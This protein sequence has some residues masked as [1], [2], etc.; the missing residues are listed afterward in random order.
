MR[1]RS[2]IVFYTELAYF[3]YGYLPS[4]FILSE[5][6]VVE[7]YKLSKFRIKISFSPFLRM[8]TLNINTTAVEI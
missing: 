1:Y 2:T 8:F 7:W 3:I 5:T 4:V 6:D